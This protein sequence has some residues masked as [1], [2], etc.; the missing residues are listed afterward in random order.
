[1]VLEDQ[2]KYYLPLHE[3][4]Q[5]KANFPDVIDLSADDLFLISK[6]SAYSTDEQNAVTVSKKMRYG[7]FKDRISTDLSI[8]KTQTDINYL[9]GQVDEVSVELCATS[10][11]LCSTIDATST[12]LSTTIQLSVD[13]LSTTVDANFIKKYGSRQY[14]FILTSNAVDPTTGRDTISAT[15]PKNIELSNGQITNIERIDVDQVFSLK[16]KSIAGGV[17]YG[18][19]YTSSDIDA[20]GTSEIRYETSC[21][22]YLDIG[23]SAIENDATHAPLEAYLIVTLN[24]QDYYRRIASFNNPGAFTGVSCYNFYH[25]SVP[26]A[27]QTRVALKYIDGSQIADGTHVQFIE[28]VFYATEANS[29]L[30]K[31]VMKD[32]VVTTGGALSLYKIKVNS[33]GLITEAQ[34]I[35]IDSSITSLDKATIDTLGLV[36]LRVT[37]GIEFGLSVDVNGAAYVKVPYATGSTPGTV[38]LGAELDAQNHIFAPKLDANSNLYVDV[39]PANASSF[40]T[41]KAA[42][43]AVSNYKNAAYGLYMNDDGFAYTAIPP[44]NVN[45]YGVVKM[46]GYDDGNGVKRPVYIDNDGTTWVRCPNSSFV[47]AYTES[48]GALADGDAVLVNYLD[49]SLKN[50]ISYGNLR[51]QIFNNLVDYLADGS[52]VQR[53]CLPRARY[54]FAYG[55]ATEQSIIQKAAAPNNDDPCR[56]VVPY[57]GYYWVSASYSTTLDIVI[58]INGNNVREINTKSWIDLFYLNAGQT[59]LVNAFRGTST[60]QGNRSIGLYYYPGY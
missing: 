18:D 38:K 54:P 28:Y 44:A 47:P 42:G 25:A 2:I 8:F 35:Q 37:S 43:A 52:G 59:V 60:A 26:L 57:D 34:P 53:G 39:T 55:T 17:I 48:L 12:L 51:T 4:D 41:V 56:L 19:V 22:C 23:I 49:N 32:G 27:E 3:L 6:V 30:S 16:G 31:Y 46:G 50:V 9:S 45:W 11:L 13:A 15:L 36:K 10:A 33:N 29:Q 40:G 5:L 1:M 24:G 58:W 14:D 7:D 21:A 20:S